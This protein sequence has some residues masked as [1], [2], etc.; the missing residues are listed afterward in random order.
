ME[1][2]QQQASK[3]WSTGLLV[4]SEV[5]FLAASNTA[6]EFPVQRINTRF[7]MLLRSFLQDA[8][9]TL[10]RRVSRCTKLGDWLAVVFVGV[11]SF[12]TFFN[13]T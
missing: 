13:C 5:L 10:A 3:R 9:A 12:S 7:F 6:A 4:F 2:R 8:Y 1:G 11:S